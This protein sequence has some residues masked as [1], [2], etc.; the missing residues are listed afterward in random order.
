[1]LEDCHF[2]DSVKL[3]GIHRRCKLTTVKLLKLFNK[4]IF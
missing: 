1:M 3:A 2:V 4:L